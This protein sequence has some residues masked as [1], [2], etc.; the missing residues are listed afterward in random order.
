MRT[1]AFDVVTLE[2]RRSHELDFARK[3]G[4]F[5]AR[6]YIAVDKVR[7]V[8]TQAARVEPGRGESMVHEQAAGREQPIEFSEVRRQGFLADMLEHTDARDLVEWLVLG[9]I[10][11]VEQ[12]HFAAIAEIA[13]ANLRA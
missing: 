3:V 12:A 9:E 8:R 2:L 13:L 6:K 5:P 7:H 10:A 4:N 11:I 1:Q